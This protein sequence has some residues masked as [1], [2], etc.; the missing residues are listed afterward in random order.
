M[1]NMPA[2]RWHSKN[3]RTAPF[4]S[5]GAIYSWERKRRDSFDPDPLYRL[6]EWSTE[7][8][9]WKQSFTKV[10]WQPRNWSSFYLSQGRHLQSFM[11]TM[12]LVYQVQWWMEPLASFPALMR[13]SKLKAKSKPLWGPGLD[14]FPVDKVLITHDR[15]HLMTWTSQLWGS[16]D[17]YVSGVQMSTSGPNSCPGTWKCVG[18]TWFCV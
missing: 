13:L 12:C 5:L 17:I 10:K 18:H 7:N 15:L 8:R 9:F 6:G 3:S 16:V 2:P 14:A 11:L 1:G 4:C